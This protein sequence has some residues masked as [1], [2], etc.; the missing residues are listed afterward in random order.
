MPKT[1]SF[2]AGSTVTIDPGLPSQE[3]AVIDSIDEDQS[4]IV[5]T[6]NLANN[7]AKGAKVVA[8][9]FNFT[10]E[11]SYKP[12]SELEFE[13]KTA[14]IKT[15]A[16]HMTISKQMAMDSPLLESLI[17]QRMRLFLQQNIERN[18]LDGNGGSTELEGILN[19]AGIQAYQRSLIPG[20]SK[21]DAI[22]RAANLAR[23]SFLPAD[24]FLIHPTDWTDIETTKGSDG[25]YVLGS[26]QVTAPTATTIWRMRPV[27]TQVITEGQA[28]V[29]AFSMGAVLWDRGEMAMAISD[30]HKDYRTRNLRLL[31]IE[32]RLGMS[33][34]RP[35]AFVDTDLSA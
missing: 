18:I 28:L 24:A 2:V 9:N 7:H 35:Q 15:I 17:E 23:L 4:R 30:D 22:R 19:T 3:T 26:Q 6:A 34:L 20:Q 1:T 27:E 12:Q 13:L 31:L 10:P 11:G 25:Q 14:A 33:V 32:E 8:L 29:G 16:T 5:F 21:L